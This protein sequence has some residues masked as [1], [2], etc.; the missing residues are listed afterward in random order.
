MKRG[1][2]ARGSVKPSAAAAV[3][4]CLAS[5]LTGCRAQQPWP[6]W[7]S[8]T[9]HF[10][11]G[12]GR[13]I[14][15]SAPSGSKD[16]TTS[17]GQAYALFFALV[18]N[19][20]PHFDK[21]LDWT[22]ANL[23]G[24]DMTLRL[25]GWVW[26][27]TDSGE[28]KIKDENPA[29]D[30]DLWMA[31]TLIQAGRLW[32]EPRYDKLGR[33]MAGLIASKEVVLVTGVGTTLLPAP[34]GFH[35]DA[36]TTWILNPSYLPLPVIAG[37][38]KE[39]PEGPW[40]SVL[41]SLP[42]ITGGPASHG[43][44]MDWV[45]ASDAGVKPTG[46]PAEPTAGHQEP[47]A[48]GSYDAIRVYLWLGLADRG[49]PELHELESQLTGMAAALQAGSP[50]PLEVDANGTVLHADAP[51]GFSAAVIPYLQSIGMKTQSRA[52]LDGLIATRDAGSGLFG[53]GQE[54]YD[55]NLALFSTG[56]VEQRYRFGRDGR[57]VVKWK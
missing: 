52:Q 43:F 11:D 16:R 21:L 30:A 9:Q 41:E 15:R 26:G 6:L 42:A 33:V 35:P 22:E 36:G 49:T 31:Y 47:Q 10:I 3:L 45:A 50:P 56:F 13:V 24:G 1:G 17:E 32:H 46:P 14:D 29:A 12:Q 44:A 20:R 25:P 18:D 48:A 39:I 28:W 27:K 55:Q 2:S 54:Y 34:T 23:A 38:A 5:S 19:D 7:E 4:C 40:G 37:L 53:H 8:Y 51:P 57:L